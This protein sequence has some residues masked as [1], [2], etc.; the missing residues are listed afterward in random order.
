VTNL[1]DSVIAVH[2]LNPFTKSDSD[3][4]RDTWESDGYQWLQKA[5]PKHVP[6]S[7]IFIYEY[8]ATVLYGKDRGAFIDKASELLEMI[9]IERNEEDTHPI[10]FLCHSM[11][12]LLVQQALVNAHNNDVYKQIKDSTTGLVFFAT[13][14]RGGKDSMVALGNMASDFAKLVRSQKGPGV[15]DVLAKGS[16]FSDILQE[17]WR[18]QLLQYDIVSFWGA[19]DDV[20]HSTAI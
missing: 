11:G 12:G 14:Q 7:R 8:N 6:G 10:I 15:M 20:S 13:P 19:Y 17:H 18:H 3:H 2:G 9:R 1:L 4:A 16:I 5:L